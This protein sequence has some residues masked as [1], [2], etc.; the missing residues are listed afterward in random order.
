MGD[1]TATL[2]ELPGLDSSSITTNTF[3]SHLRNRRNLHTTM[4]ASSS[5]PPIKSLAS[6][7]ASLVLYHRPL[8]LAHHYETSSDLTSHG[9]NDLASLHRD[10]DSGG[11]SSFIMLDKMSS[12]IYLPAR[13]IKHTHFATAQSM[14]MPLVV[15]LPAP[16]KD[17]LIAR[18]MET[19]IGH[20]TLHAM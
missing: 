18:T 5:R 12:T 11:F 6:L 10:S 7:L 19:L 3:S 8:N 20:P 16:G 13:S 4:R 2:V 15:P 14:L 9:V 1:Q 17:D